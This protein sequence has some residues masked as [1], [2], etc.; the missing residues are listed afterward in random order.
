MEAIRKAAQE[1]YQA[2]R[3]Q[4]KE[5]ANPLSP[6]DQTI[7]SM[8]DASPTKWHLA[9]TSWFFEAFILAPH[10]KEYRVID[11]RYH[12]LFNSYYFSQGQ[13]YSRPHR[14]LITRP[15]VEEVRHY[16]EVVDR[17]ILAFIEEVDETKWQDIAPLL[18]L[19]LHHEQQ[20]QEL[21]LTDIKHAFSF[22]PCFPAYQKTRTKIASTSTPLNWHTF[23]EGK[24]EIGHDGNGFA[25]D[26]ELPRHHVLLHGF[27]I[28]SRLT[29]NAEFIEFIKDG[30]YKNPLLWLSDGWSWVAK[31]T[32]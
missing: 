15:N 10:K 26:N 8:A 25:Y 14:F 22:N 16:R 5:L 18:T 2:I 31:N 27:E 32:S 17:E 23:S 19:G 28:A 7:Q 20:H 6:E 21:I 4:T 13:Q 12:A 9:H 1:A 24:G 29:T 3:A 11:E 30:G